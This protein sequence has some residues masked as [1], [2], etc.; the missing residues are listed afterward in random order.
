[1]TVLLKAIPHLFDAYAE[2]M[3]SLQDDVQHYQV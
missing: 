2:D 3:F 1:M